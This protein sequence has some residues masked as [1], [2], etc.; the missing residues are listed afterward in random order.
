VKAWCKLPVKGDPGASLTAVRQ[1]SV[2]DFWF[3]SSTDDN[4]RGDFW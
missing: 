3:C 2:K 4:S 1:G